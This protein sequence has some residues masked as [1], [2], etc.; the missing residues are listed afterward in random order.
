M[1]SGYTDGLED[2]EPRNPRWLLLAVAVSVLLWAII[3]GC[4]CALAQTGAPSQCGPT[5][6]GATAAP[7]TYPA[8]G[9]TGPSFP[10]KFVSIAVP[11]GSQYACAATTGTAATSGSGCA[12]GAFY[13]GP[14]APPLT[15]AQP[16]YPPP[17]G[18]S[19]VGSGS[20]TPLTCA[21]Q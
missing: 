5:S 11:N 2:G 15:W 17:A 4:A 13:I 6:I 16:S 21:Y 1:F 9:G 19:V 18:I 14:F 3:I 10:T 7:I 12:A 20:G 8:S